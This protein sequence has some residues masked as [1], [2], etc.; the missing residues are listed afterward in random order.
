MLTVAALV[1]VPSDLEGS[2][3]DIKFQQLENAEGIS[4]RV[5]SGCDESRN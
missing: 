2:W 1:G 4:S 5:V 3:N